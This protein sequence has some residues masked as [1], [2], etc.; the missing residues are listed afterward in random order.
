MHFRLL[1]VLSVTL[2]VI[3]GFPDASTQ[4]L[5]P[6]GRNSAQG[7][8]NGLELAQRGVYTHLFVTW[9]ASGAIVPKCSEVNQ[10]KFQL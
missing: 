5:T 1:F 2:K 7:A 3:G 10:S 4:D 6:I 8:G 9:T